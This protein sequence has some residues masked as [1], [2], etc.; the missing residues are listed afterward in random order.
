MDA[1]LLPLDLHGKPQHPIGR[2]SWEE[3][4]MSRTLRLLVAGIAT[5]VAGAAG[6]RDAR[7]DLNTIHTGTICR[8][9]SGSMGITTDG[10]IYNTSTSTT[11]WVECPLPVPG[12]AGVVDIEMEYLDNS[13]SFIN[14]TG[15]A[16]DDLST[17]RN[18]VSFISSGDDNY[19][20]VVSVTNQYLLGGG[21][22]VYC[23]VPPRDSS[24]NPS[25]IIGWQ[26]S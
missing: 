22:H 4:V 20:R 3:K 18:S 21:Y 6:V 13:T 25:Y 7:A 24:G 9:V 12:T 26:T 16:E 17:S 19:Y 23:S 10:A 5:V 15:Y 11:L 1:A 8:A 14:C 2:G